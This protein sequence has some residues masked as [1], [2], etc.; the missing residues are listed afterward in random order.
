MFAGRGSCTIFVLSWCGSSREACV[1]V[2]ACPF[3]DVLVM[4]CLGFEMQCIVSF[5][6]GVSGWMFVCVRVGVLVDA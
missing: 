4:G 5:L 1:C 6:F 2:H 3:R